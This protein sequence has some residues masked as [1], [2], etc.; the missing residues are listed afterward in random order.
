M[1]LIKYSGLLTGIWGKL[2]GSVFTRNRS[3]SIIKNKSTPHN[4]QSGGQTR[5]RASMT[6]LSRKWR[7][8][9]FTQRNNW[10]DL[11]ELIVLHNYWG[12][13]YSPSGFNLFCRLNQNLFL[14]SEPYIWDAPLQVDV[15]VLSDVFCNPVQVGVAN[16]MFRFQ[17]QVT[18]SDIIHIIYASPGISA[19]KYYNKSNFKIIGSIP[20][21]T[22]NQFQ[23]YSLFTNAY[24]IPRLNQKIFFKLRAISKTTGFDSISS[25][26][27]NLCQSPSIGI[28]YDTIG[29]TLKVY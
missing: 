10:N 17:D 22:A 23:A 1:G 14:I 15:P 4:P 5:N 13:S 8:L 11:S 6:F 9:T 19:G 29:S 28:G 25:H 16:M 18:D 26:F 20:A 7:E 3:G 12:D 2:N 21:G 24:S 27:N